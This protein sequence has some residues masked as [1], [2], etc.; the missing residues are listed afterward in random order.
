MIPRG[1]IIA[2]PA[3]GAGKTVLTL[4]ALRALAERNVAGAKAGPDYI[5]PAGSLRKALF[6]SR[7]RCFVAAIYPA[8]K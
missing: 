7:R 2:A 1:I 8:R 5:D 6:Q 4:G 3:S